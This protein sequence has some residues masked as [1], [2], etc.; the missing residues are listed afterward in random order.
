MSAPGPG[1]ITVLDQIHVSDGAVATNTRYLI[2]YSNKEPEVVGVHAMIDECSSSSDVASVSV[3]AS[4]GGVSIVEVLD[5]SGEHNGIEWEVRL[6]DEL[7]EYVC[8][9]DSG[10]SH[11][12]DR[13]VY[14]VHGYATEGEE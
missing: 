9:T 10:R 1:G 13:R 14:V 5:V 11:V 4:D 8:Y 6:L 2:V 3:I 12:D 7:I